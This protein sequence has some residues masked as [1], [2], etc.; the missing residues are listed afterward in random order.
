M[1]VPLA[2]FPRKPRNRRRPR[3]CRRRVHSAR[4]GL[5]SRRS[6]ATARAF[7]QSPEQ[8]L[9]DAGVALAPDRHGYVVGA[10]ADLPE[11]SHTGLQAGDRILSVNGLAVG[12]PGA[13]RLKIEDFLANGAARLEIQ[14]GDRRVVLTVSVN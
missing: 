2:A 6:A 9:A 4:P 11:L 7:E 8:A 1:G 13:D 14:R 3:W 12:D 5:P 10:L